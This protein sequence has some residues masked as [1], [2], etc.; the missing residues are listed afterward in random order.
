MNA[1][2]VSR[3]LGVAGVAG[4]VGGV[5]ALAAIGGTLGYQQT[6]VAILMEWARGGALAGAYV[7]AAWGLGAWLTPYLL[8]TEDA[9]WVAPAVGLGLMLAISHAMG[10]LGMFDVG[11][12][13]AAAAPLA[14]GL[15]LLAW[16]LLQRRDEGLALH[17]A[18][19]CVVPGA[20][21]LIVAAA[22]PP[23]WLWASEGFGYD[24]LGYHLQLPGEWA[25]DG[26]LWPVEHNVYSHLPGYVEAAFL[27]MASVLGVGPGV[28]I[29]SGGGT[30]ILAAQ[31]LSAWTALLAAVLL[32]RVCYAACRAVETEH[33]AGIAT[34]CA[35]VALGTPWMLV[36]GTLAY[37][38][39]AVLAL[40]AG[41]ML[42]AMDGGARPLVRWG[43]AAF[44][45]GS[46][47]GA[48]PTALFMV[49][50][51]VGLLL[52]WRT[53][54]RWWLAFGGVAVVVGTLTLVPWLARNW[55]AAGNPVF[56]AL[57]GVFGLGHWTAEQHGRW[58][59]GHAFDGSLGD[60][61][62][63]LA[64]GDR[65]LLHPQWGVLGVLMVLGV[66]ACGVLRGGVR[67]VLV[68]G[69]VLQLAAWYALTHLQ[70]RFLMPLMLTGVPAIAVALS[71]LRRPAAAVIAASVL[72]TVQAGFAVALYAGERNGSP[73]AA[74]ATG[75]APFTTPPADA[76]RAGPVPLLNNLLPRDARVLLVF[77]ARP[78]YLTRPVLYSTTWDASSLAKAIAASPDDPAS[79]VAALQGRGVRWML[80]H[81][82]EFD[83]LG[84][85]GWLD[86]ALTTE[87]LERLLGQGRVVRAWDGGVLLVDLGAAAT[88]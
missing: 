39:P 85:S 61:L 68:A 49:T 81:T 19:L 12:R 46:A 83:R 41:A 77:D 32:A 34:A 29:A 25:R 48:K 58:K 66:A 53:P 26:R 24:T 88:P 16:R 28:P 11:G 18:A 63:M 31:M 67:L 30:A 5:A 79:W 54:A 36:T 42:G 45:V 47:C 8:K 71:A 57:D 84:R 40:G 80:V 4:L 56:P 20:A 65:G 3:L 10:V 9:P 23:G 74:I 22:S 50:P 14:A 13:V 60:R 17:P 27:H 69:F 21:V 1:G 38:E 86:P 70:S 55:A 2:G 15:G 59:S 51:V 64:S 43:V 44:L 72:A 6:L 62:A 76:S 33:A 73:N 87:N 82:G 52:L 78:L 75:V 7:A 37:N 35:A